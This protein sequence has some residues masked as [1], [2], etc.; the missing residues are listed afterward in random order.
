VPGGAEYLDHELV[1][2]GGAGNHVNDLRGLG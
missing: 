2:A 1:C